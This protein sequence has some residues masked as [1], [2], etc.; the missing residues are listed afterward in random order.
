M[1]NEI[2]NVFLHDKSNVL[3]NLTSNSSENKTTTIIAKEG[4]VEEKRMILFDGNIITTSNANSKNDL[5][6]FTQLN[7]DLA[8]LQTS[9][10]KVPK[11]QETS[12]LDLLKCIFVSVDEEI[13]N[14]KKNTKQEITTVLNRRIILPFYIPII[15]LL[16]SFLLIKN[17]SKKKIFLNKYFIFALSFLI[18]LYAE[19]II[20]YTGI[21][22]IISG[23]F[24]FSP[25]ILTPLIYFLLIYKFSKESVIR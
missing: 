23:L 13:L 21:S 11:L 20:R 7:I 1:N 14:C 24:I 4:V 9:T 16:C 18:L 10:I 19:L 2:K 15:A 25:F 17:N 22:K 5:I 12:T 3:K 6:K 8:N